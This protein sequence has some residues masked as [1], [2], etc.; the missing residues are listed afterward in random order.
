MCGWYFLMCLFEEYQVYQ[1]VIFWLIIE[2]WFGGVLELG[3]QQYQLVEVYWNVYGY[4]LL[5][6][7]VVVVFDDVVMYVVVVGVV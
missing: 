4:F 5:V 2:C 1:L 6:V 3:L 7:V